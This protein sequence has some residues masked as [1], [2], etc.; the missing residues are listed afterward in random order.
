MVFFYLS[1]LLFSGFLQFKVILY[2]ANI[3]TVNWETAV[4][5]TLVYSF[6][7]GESNAD[8]RSGRGYRD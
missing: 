4:A 3:I 6:N 5:A 2:V 8:D 1:K 7:T